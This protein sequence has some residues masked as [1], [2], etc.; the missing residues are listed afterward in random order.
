[1]NEAAVIARS[2]FDNIELALQSEHDVLQDTL[3]QSTGNSRWP[4]DT[5]TPVRQRM[6]NWSNVNALDLLRRFGIHAINNHLGKF[7]SGYIS[8]VHAWTSPIRLL[9][10]GLGAQV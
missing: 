1:M 5:R 6:I 7:G 10:G 9:G 3:G 2:L 8:L 4:I